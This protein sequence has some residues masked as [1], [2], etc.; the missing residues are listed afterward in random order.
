MRYAGNWARQPPFVSRGQN[1]RS[2]ARGRA[3]TAGRQRRIL[4]SESLVAAR[5]A[6]ETT[7][8]YV[9]WTKNLKVEFEQLTIY[10]VKSDF[11]RDV[12]Q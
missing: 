3:A 6:D 4:A 12:V 11:F 1:R 5:L 8:T 10:D 2:L 9:V 7:R